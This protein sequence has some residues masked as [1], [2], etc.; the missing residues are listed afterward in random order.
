MSTE[1]GNFSRMVKHNASQLFRMYFLHVDFSYFLIIYS[2]I[3]YM[4]AL[5]HKDFSPPTTTLII[6]D[7]M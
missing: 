4:R 7:F 6:L 5:R 2:I 1:N 3:S